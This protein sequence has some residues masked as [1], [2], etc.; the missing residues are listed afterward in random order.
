MKI[1]C[2]NNPAQAAGESISQLLEQHNGD[3]LCLLSGGSALQV[4][5]HIQKP[6]SECRTIFMLG[7]ERGSREPTVNNFLQLQSTWPDSWVTDACLE[8]VPTEAESLTEFAE[9]FSKQLDSTINDLQNLQIVYL[10]G[11]GHDG[12]T[13][14]VFPLDED[15]FTRIYEHDQSIVPV[16]LD[17]L[18]I[19]S[20]ASVTP[21]WVLNHVDHIIGYATGEFKHTILVSLRNESKAIHERPAEL[22]KQKSGSMVFT[23]QIID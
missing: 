10:M 5:Q 18:T 2:S 23:D 6:T 3:T 22:W 4:V 14:G 8:T 13:A 16:H 1:V 21:Q 12:H 20:R 9:R 17:A 11:M 7:D 15:Q 19:D